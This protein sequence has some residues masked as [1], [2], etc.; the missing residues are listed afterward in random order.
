MWDDDDEVTV[1]GLTVLQGSTLQDV[2]NR[3]C[4]NRFEFPR[5]SL[6]MPIN[7]RGCYFCAEKTPCTYQTASG[8]ALYYNI[9]PCC[10]ECAKQEMELVIDI[11][12]F[13]KAV[14][15]MMVETA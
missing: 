6:L 8:D 1:P 7:D 10:P 4:V 11:P 13:V 5:L 3:Q 12:E 14:N 15:R 2:K 9:I